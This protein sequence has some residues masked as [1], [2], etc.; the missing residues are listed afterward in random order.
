MRRLVMIALVVSIQ[1]ALLGVMIWDRL[2]LLNTG[3]EVELSVEP[4]DPRSLFRGDYVILTYRIS[5][6]NTG[7]LEGDDAFSRND[8]IYVELVEKDSAWLPVAIYRALPTA[9]TS[10]G[11]VYIR[12]RVASAYP[13][14][15]T[16]VPT[17]TEENGSEAPI[18]DGTMLR[19]E[20][21]IESYFVPEGEGRTLE[22][23]RNEE[24][25]SVVVAIGRDGSAAIKRLLL[26]G[27]VYHEE[28]LL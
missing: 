8:H 7:A 4:V 21:G 23:A 15:P 10:P 13:A 14:S 24:R 22:D 1:S 20:Y 5:R 6:L 28:G 17:E 11:Q 18:P 2:S 9:A 27:I 12:G 19:I 3:Q 25:M 26:D 16:A